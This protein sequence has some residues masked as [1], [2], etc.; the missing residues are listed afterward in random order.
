MLLRWYVGLL[1][2]WGRLRL[3]VD[4]WICWYGLSCWRADGRP[5]AHWWVLL[6]EDRWCCGGLRRGWRRKVGGLILR[7]CG[8]ALGRPRAAE[9]EVGVVACRSRV[10][11]WPEGEVRAGRGLLL[12]GGGSE[13]CCAGP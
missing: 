10:G 11:G 9:G 5:H 13:V 4:C 3:M 6:W 12:S 2:V 7:G 1:R 8:R